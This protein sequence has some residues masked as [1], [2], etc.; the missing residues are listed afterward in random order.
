MGPNICCPV[1]LYVFSCLLLITTL[2]TKKSGEALGKGLSGLVRALSASCQKK[3]WKSWRKRRRGVMI[4]GNGH[5]P[6]IKIANWKNL[7]IQLSNGSVDWEGED[8][9][10]WSSLSHNKENY[11]GDETKVKKH[12]LGLGVLFDL[13]CVFYCHGYSCRHFFKTSGKSMNF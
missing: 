10:L 13:T 5:R 2:K 1:H 4:S 8:C 11:P 6:K 3:L 9:I 7:F 12:L